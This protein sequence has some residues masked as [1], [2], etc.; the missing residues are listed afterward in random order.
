MLVS[1]AAPPAAGAD[2]DPMRTVRDPQSRF[3]IDVPRSWQVTTGGGNPALVA[4]APA[5]HAGLLPATV[6]VIVYDLPAAI[7]PAT[8][9]RESQ[10][11]MR[12]A[13]GAVSPLSQGPGSVARLPAYAQAYTW[14]TKSGEERRSLEVCLLVGRRAILMIGTTANVPDRIHDDLPILDLIIHSLRPALRVP[15]PDHPAPPGRD[16]D[17][18]GM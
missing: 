12:L 17:G 2:D 5:D 14:R 16:R 11:F 18:M 13:I 7:S 4:V 10:R 15:E 9:V 1:L 3:T 6:N 8:C